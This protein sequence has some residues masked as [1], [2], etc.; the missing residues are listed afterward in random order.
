WQAGFG[1][2]TGAKSSDGD[3]DADADVDG[4]D[5]LIWQQNY[6]PS[7][8]GSGAI[9]STDGSVFK[10]PYQPDKPPRHAARPIVIPNQ[11]A[12]DS[13]FASL[14]QRALMWPGLPT[15]PHMNV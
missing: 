5:F 1:T 11:P 6:S 12:R 4:N 2:R 14:D 10:E 13:I 9:V 3:S 15:R 7:S 8:A